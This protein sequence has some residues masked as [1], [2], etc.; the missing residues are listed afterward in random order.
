MWAAIAIEKSL[1]RSALTESANALRAKQEVPS[2]T[3]HQVLRRDRHR[4]Q[5][6]SCTHAKFVDVH[7]VEHAKTAADKTPK[8]SSRC[9]GAHHRACHR[10][11]PA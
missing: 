3:R 7:H 6:P 1:R 5:V 11:G 8:I 4:C 2:A 10:G 9:A